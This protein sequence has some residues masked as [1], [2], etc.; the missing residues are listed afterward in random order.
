MGIEMT[1]KSGRD[2]RIQIT[3]TM[4]L[5]KEPVEPDGADDGR[6]EKRSSPC[7]GRGPVGDTRVFF[8]V[9]QLEIGRPHPLSISSGR[10]HALYRLSECDKVLTIDNDVY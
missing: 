2:G 7:C 8:A 4:L 3:G 9:S 1:R 10:S 5:P 6:T